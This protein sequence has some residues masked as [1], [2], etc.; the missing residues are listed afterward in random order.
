MD[1]RDKGNFSDFDTIDRMKHSTT[2]EYSKQK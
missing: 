1:Q 2:H